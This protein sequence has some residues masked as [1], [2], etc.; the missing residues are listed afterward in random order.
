M[1]NYYIILT[2]KKENWDRIIGRRRTSLAEMN[3]QAEWVWS[4]F[5]PRE[6]KNY[7]VLVQGQIRP[8]ER[9]FDSDNLN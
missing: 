7:R 4:L 2:N 9:Y 6:K 8:G 1:R 5:K 3:A